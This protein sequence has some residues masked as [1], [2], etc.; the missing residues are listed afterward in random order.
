[1][2]DFPPKK[3]Q[4][5]ADKG[6]AMPGGGFP[7][8]NRA[9]LQRAIQAIGRASNPDAAKAWIKKRA[10]ELNAIDLIP[11]SWSMSHYEK[12]S[13]DELTELVHHGVKG[14]RWGVRSRSSGGGVLQRQASRQTDRAIRLHTNARDNKGIIGKVA[15]LD[16]HTWGRSGRFEG[17]HNKRI[18][19]LER[20][21]ERI[22]QGE[23]VARTLVLG[24]KYSKT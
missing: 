17:Y 9:D 7:I 13:L 12:P 6:Q 8:R 23:L 20:S 22:A 5:L 18:G 21:K 10:R 4:Q 24:P 19:E 16:K 14:M 3:R 1:M 2:P 15:L 11:E